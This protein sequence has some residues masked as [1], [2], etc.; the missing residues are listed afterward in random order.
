MKGVILDKLTRR[1]DERL[2]LSLFL[3]FVFVA[4]TTEKPDSHRYV[5]VKGRRNLIATVDRRG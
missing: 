1:A 5:V 3:S 2:A 4:V